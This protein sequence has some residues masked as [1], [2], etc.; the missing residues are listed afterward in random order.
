MSP[1][2]YT[3]TDYIINSGAVIYYLS[4]VNNYWTRLSK[5]L[6]FVSGKQINYWS[7]RH[8][9]ITI[10]CD[11]RVQ[12]NSLSIRSASLFFNEYLREAKRSA[13]FNARATARTRKA[14]FRLHMSRILFA[15]KHWSQTQ[16][17]DIEHEQTIICRQLFAGHVVGFWPMKRKKNLHQMII[18]ITGH[19]GKCDSLGTEIEKITIKTGVITYLLMFPLRALFWTIQLLLKKKI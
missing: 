10:F 13:I 16:L 7:A 5:I 14:W 17:D 15:A 11:N 1:N 3:I 19:R 12:C 18:S 8:W 4:T 9:Q 6:W 2:D